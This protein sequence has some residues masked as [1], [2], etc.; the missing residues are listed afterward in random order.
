MVVKLAIHEPSVFALGQ[1]I[2]LGGL[3]GQEEPIFAPIDRSMRC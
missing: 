2:A 1:K 3:A